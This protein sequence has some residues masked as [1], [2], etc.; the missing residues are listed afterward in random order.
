MDHILLHC[1]MVKEL[2]TTI[3]YLLGVVWVLHNLLRDLL[4]WKEAVWRKRPRKVAMAVDFAS[5][6]P[7][8]RC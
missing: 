4:R 2:W 7:F 6:G 5:F 1:C 8:G 3:F